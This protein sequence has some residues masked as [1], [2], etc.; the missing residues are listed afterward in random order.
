MKR[1]CNKFIAYFQAY[2]N[3]H[4]PVDYLRYIFT[5]AM[6][7]SEVVLLSIAT[8]PDC[9]SPAILNLLV[10]LNQIKPVW[11]ELG[12]QTIHPKTSVFIRSGFTLECFHE[13]VRHLAARSLPVIVHTILGLPGETRAEMLETISH[14]GSLNVFG[15]KLQLLHVLSDTDLG[16][17]FQEQPFPLFSQKEYCEL[18][19]DCLELLPPTI[20]IHRL[21]GDGPKDLLLGPHWS[22][23]KRSVLNQIHKTLGDR[24]T[25]QGKEYTG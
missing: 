10:E 6:K 17:L 13:A 18:A 4:A 25:W 11:I 14:V 5:E 19:A 12:L 7:D 20:T 16:I 3:T 21:T 23:S 9:L 1:G 24:D 8:R 22:S 2:T 15:I